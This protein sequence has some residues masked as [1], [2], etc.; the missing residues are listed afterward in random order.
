MYLC[1]VLFPHCFFPFFWTAWY[2]CICSILLGACRI[3]CLFVVPVVPVV[4]RVT[5]RPTQWD[6]DV[7]R[8]L[9]S[10]SVCMGVD[11]FYSND[12]RWGQRCAYQ[13]LR[14]RVLA[15]WASWGDSRLREESNEPPIRLQS[16][17]IECFKP[18]R[19]EPF[20]RECLLR[21][22]RNLILVGPL[23]RRKMSSA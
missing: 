1:E 14:S 7:H 19:T 12:G 15:L 3:C 21:R 18:N 2:M 22:A 23:D 8:W 16:A 4:S 6:W 13:Y 5:W 10:E 11:L 20:R 17:T 9:R